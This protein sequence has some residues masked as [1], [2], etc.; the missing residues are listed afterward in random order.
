M[1]TTMTAA[2]IAA[3]ASATSGRSACKSCGGTH[4]RTVHRKVKFM[5]QRYLVPHV[6]C[7]SCWDE[8]PDV[9]ALPTPA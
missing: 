5:G 6:R 7:D 4:L 3:L 2:R 9:N 8:V 1:A